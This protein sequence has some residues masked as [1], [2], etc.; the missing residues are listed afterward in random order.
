MPRQAKPP[1]LYPRK[2]QRDKDG[3]I[4]RAA[5]WI[6][7]DAGRQFGTGCDAHD[8]ERANKA[9]AAYIG[10]KYTAAARSRPRDTNEIPVADVLNLYAKDVV[11]KHAH[12]AAAIGRLQRLGDFF[13]NKMLSDINGPLCRD[14]AAKQTTDTVARSDLVVLNAAINHHL[15]EGLHD[16]IIKV[17]KPNRRPPRE[18]WLT[19]SEAVQLILKAWR[20]KE[21]KFGKV[22][23]RHPR[24]HLARFLLVGLYTGSRA[25]VIASAS[26]EKQPGQTTECFTAAPLARRKRKSV[27]L[28]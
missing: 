15:K 19:R 24:R 11:P 20:A 16:R 9:L 6:I 23:E 25:D 8:L 3:R 5:G 13:G 10:R 26:F 14:Y 21:V 28:L 2:E 18:R 27:G 17:W 7:L 12:P 22:T 1:R 4:I